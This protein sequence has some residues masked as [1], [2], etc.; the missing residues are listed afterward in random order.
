MSRVTGDDKLMAE[1]RAY[2]GMSPEGAARLL[3]DLAVPGGAKNFLDRLKSVPAA[4]VFSRI[5]PRAEG[6]KRQSA[7]LRQKVLEVL[8]QAFSE[9]R[10]DA[11]RHGHREPPAK[12]VNARAAELA[13]CSSRLVA[14]VREEARL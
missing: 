11:R 6:R 10:E 4:L 2:A 3:E 1:T 5:D 9:A 7:A 14:Y 13:N 12:T 8:P